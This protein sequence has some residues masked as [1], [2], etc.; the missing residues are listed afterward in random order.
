VK[1][2]NKKITL[3][4]K[5]VEKETEQ[6]TFLIGGI[7]PLTGDASYY[8]IT[9]KQGAEIAVKEINA[10]GG[11]TVGNQKVKLKLDF[12]DDE[13]TGEKAVTCYKQ[14]KDAGADAILGTVSSVACLAVAELTNQDGIFQLTPT[15]LAASI[16]RYSNVFRLCKS[17]AAQ[18]VDMADYAVKVLG[19]KKIAVLYDS[20]D[21]YSTTIKDAFEDQV[22]EN[23]GKL[24]ITE[25]L[26]MSDKDFT[27]Q[28]TAIKKSDANVIF[29]PLYYPT[30]ATI[31]AQAA[32]LN[33][34]LP[35]LGCDGWEGILTF[36]SDLSSLEGSAFNCPFF[37]TDPDKSIQTFVKKYKEAYNTVPDQFAADGYDSV[38]VIA[39]AMNKAGSTKSSELIAAMPKI[40]IKGLTGTITYPNNGDPKKDIKVAVIRD[41]KYAVK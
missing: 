33:I 2:Y 1:G 25:E 6:S 23:G 9:V 14:L 36:S 4:I 40:E 10:A 32:Q 38:Y 22:A 29:M 37:A 31:T 41:G 16:T 17:D 21:V 15:A 7:G 27:N 12:R 26:Q 39:A 8:G 35:M 24:V 18:G 28:L 13:L 34:K 3:K 5:V 30:V 19:L 11:V 20:S